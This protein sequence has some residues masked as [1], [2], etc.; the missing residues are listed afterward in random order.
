MTHKGEYLKII[1]RFDKRKER[2]RRKNEREVKQ[3]IKKRALSVGVDMINTQHS[4]SATKIS[5]QEELHR[6]KFQKFQDFI[7]YL[8]DYHKIDFY[9]EVENGK[10]NWF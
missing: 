4:L 5:Y 7:I 9:F 3:F 10:F 8:A 6:A 2:L 1:N